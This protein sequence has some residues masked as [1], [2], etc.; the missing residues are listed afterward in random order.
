MRWQKLIVYVL[1]VAG[2]AFVVCAAYV[3]ALLLGV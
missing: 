3:D 1:A 2:L